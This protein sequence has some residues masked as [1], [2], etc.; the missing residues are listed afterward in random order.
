V[1]AV[2]AV[3]VAVGEADGAGR[4]GAAVVPATELG[5][6]VLDTASGRDSV[7]PAAT[8]WNRTS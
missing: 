6:V 3:D 7:G 1:E 5:R 2:G 4:E 8:D